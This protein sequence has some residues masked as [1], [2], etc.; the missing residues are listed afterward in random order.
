MDTKTCPKCGAQW[1]GGQHFW[2]G[3]NKK[4]NETELASLVCDRFGYE[5]CINPC[6]GTTNGK[7]WEARLSSMNDIEKDLD[8][9]LNE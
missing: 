2:T 1:I 5:N 7:G 9:S 8:R 4:G 3:T 6:K